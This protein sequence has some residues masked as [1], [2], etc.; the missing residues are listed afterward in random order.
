MKKLCLKLSIPDDTCKGCPFLQRKSKEVSYQQDRIW[1]E[2][3]V[4]N[5]EITNY[6]RCVACQSCEVSE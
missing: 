3:R 1:H 6:V 4:F 2:C 5:C